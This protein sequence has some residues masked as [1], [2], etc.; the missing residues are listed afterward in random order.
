M[1]NEVLSSSG[2]TRIKILLMNAGITAADIAR[3]CNVHRSFVTHVIAGRVK[4]KR[5]RT[6]IAKRLQV[7]LAELWPAGK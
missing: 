5:I 6:A 7:P 3:E 4:T 2:A 1:L